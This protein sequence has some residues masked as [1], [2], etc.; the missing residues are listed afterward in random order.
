[1]VVS[2]ID[3]LLHFLYALVR[4]RARGR[5]NNIP[6]E[7]EYVDHHS[8]SHADADA[9]ASHKTAAAAAEIT[10]TR[11]FFDFDS[12]IEQNERK[13]NGFPIYSEGTKPAHSP[14]T[15]ANR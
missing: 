11:R 10:M 12:Q 15:Q 8:K 4:A 1:M 7:E 14:H 9:A 5:G 6:R 3:N 2:P 13:S